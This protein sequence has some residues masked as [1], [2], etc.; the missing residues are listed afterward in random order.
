MRIEVKPS[1]NDIVSFDLVVGGQLISTPTYY[2]GLYLI[3]IVTGSATTAASYDFD[4]MKEPD[5]SVGYHRTY[6]LSLTTDGKVTTNTVDSRVSGRE[7]LTIGDCTLD[8]LALDS[9]VAFPERPMQTRHT[10]YSPALR[11]F[12]REAIS[13][14]GSPPAWVIYDHIEP[15]E[16]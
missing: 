5:L 13:N 3:R 1:N 9:Q 2:G 15:V 14:D 11:T 6:H 10:N 16:R 12:V 8:T 4:Y 7:N